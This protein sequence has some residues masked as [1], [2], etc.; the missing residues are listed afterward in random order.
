MPTSRISIADCLCLA[1]LS[2]VVAG[3]QP[4]A[5]QGGQ[6]RFEGNGPIKIVCTTQ[7]VADAL[8]NIAGQHAQ[9][10]ALMGPGVDPHLYRTKPSDLLKLQDADIVFYNGLH[11]E[12]RVADALEQLGQR[13]PVV[14]L[15]GKLEEGHD[16]RLLSPTDA[17]GVHDPHL[18]H[19]VQLWSDCVGYAAE[20][21]AEFD[22]ARANDYRANAEAYRAELAELDGEVRAA[23][24]S[25]PAEGRLL[26]TAHDA[27]GYFSK[28]YG[29]ETIGLK[30]IS[31][32]DEADFSHLDHVREVLV[33]R[34]VPA[35]FVESSTS[36]R[37]VNKLIEEC[38][39]S[40]H[41]VRVGDELYSDAMGPAG[42][43][44]ETYTGM[45]RANVAAIVEGLKE[46][47]K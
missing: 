20:R 19:D 3:C 35:V 44:A 11:L 47:E 25:I 46:A 15:A 42:S 23:I 31:T 10:E 26:V 4:S 12:G 21:L 45:I 27:F 29:I 16:P 34:E 40:G 24:E 5:E 30:G 8:Q 17:S 33:E 2:G 32:E 39:A 38:A 43:G 22:P 18:W 41:E 1:L 36:P 7:Q 9:I 6:F 13:K 37:L 14:P 28:A